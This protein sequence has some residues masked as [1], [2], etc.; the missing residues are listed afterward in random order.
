MSKTAKFGGTN[1]YDSKW[2]YG[3]STPNQHQSSNNFNNSLKAFKGGGS[4]KPT[5]E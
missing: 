2:N 1:N 5:H 3:Y 4:Y